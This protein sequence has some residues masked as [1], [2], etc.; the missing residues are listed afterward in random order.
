MVKILSIL[1]IWVYFDVWHAWYYSVSA[2]TP[3]ATTPAT[4]LTTIAVTTAGKLKLEL[5]DCT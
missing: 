2:T 1:N 3:V 4:K 5:L